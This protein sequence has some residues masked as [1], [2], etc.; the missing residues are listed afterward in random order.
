MFSKKNKTNRNLPQELV[1]QSTVIEP[2]LMG[3][4]E[5]DIKKNIISVNSCLKNMLGY[6]D[7]EQLANHALWQALIGPKDQ[8]GTG[9]VFEKHLNSPDNFPHQIEAPFQHKDGS[10]VLVH[11]SRKVTEWDENYEPSIMVA[12]CINTIAHKQLEESLVA[13][14]AELQRKNIALQEIIAGVEHE[15]NK[16]KQTVH[17][18]LNYG[19]SPII[20]RLKK[21]KSGLELTLLEMIENTLEMVGEELFSRQDKVALKLS[22]KEIQVCLLVKNGLSVKEIAQFYNLS[23]RTI[24]KHR[25]N[26]REKL[27]LRGAAV[28]LVS[29]LRDITL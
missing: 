18:K 16:I 27:G 8:C 26:I 6:D 21:N 17:Q 29:F 19:I 24:D 14:R 12:F 23:E 10:T 7:H 13:A 3:Y 22:P 4:W 9:K 25:E 28:N 15:K 5:W 11:C 2:I 1:K 20:T